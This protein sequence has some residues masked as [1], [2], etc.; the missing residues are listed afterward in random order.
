M[1]SGILLAGGKSKRMGTEKAILP[2]GGKLLYEYPLSILQHFCDEILISSDSASLKEKCHYPFIQDEKPGI[3]PLMGIY[4]CMKKISNSVALVLSC[5]N[6]NISIGF[7]AY[8]LQNSNSSQ[9]TLGIGPKGLPEPLSGIYH[10][11]IIPIAH[12]LLDDGDY[13]LSTLIRNSKTC[14]VDP[15]RAGFVPNELFMNINTVEDFESIK[16]K[17]N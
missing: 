13:R 3:G 5:D 17:Y 9:I 11:E 15:S 6:P 1:I 10:K 2:L 7:I 4:T 12:S 16:R 8:L 14:L